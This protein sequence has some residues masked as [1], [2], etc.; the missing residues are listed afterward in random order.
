MQAVI[1]GGIALLN[2]AWL[3]GESTLA[4][5]VLTRILATFSAAFELSHK[6]HAQRFASERKVE[7]VRAPAEEASALAPAGAASL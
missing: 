1:P 6:R 4:A 2:C 5:R 3:S 7:N